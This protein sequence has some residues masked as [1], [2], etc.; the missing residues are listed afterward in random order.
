[1]RSHILVH[2]GTIK[3]CSNSFVFKNEIE[4]EG[5]PRDIAP[6]L[7]AGGLRFK[8]GRP[9][10]IPTIHQILALLHCGTTWEQQEKF[11]KLTDVETWPKPMQT[12]SSGTGLLCAK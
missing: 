5:L 10:Q 1:M 7:G 2:H 3:F 4:K 9:D 6:A 8:S 12:L 11:S